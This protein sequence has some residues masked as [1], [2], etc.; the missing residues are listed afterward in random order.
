MIRTIF[1]RCLVLL[2]LALLSLPASANAQLAASSVPY[3]SGFTMVGGPPGTDFSGAL[4]LFAY[5]PSGYSS[6]AVKQATLCGGYWAYFSQPTQVTIPASAGG[7]QACPLQ[8]GWNLVGNP[9]QTP[10]ALPAGLT[11][12]YWDTTTNQYTTVTSIPVGGAVWVY[13]SAPASIMLSTPGTVII[14]SLTSPGPYTAHVGDIVEL[15]IPAQPGYM[16]SA[17]PVYLQLVGAGVTGPLSCL[18][19]SC[20]L[21]LNNNFFKWK[22]IQAGTTAI[23]VSPLCLRTVPPCGLPS[24]AISVTILP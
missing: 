12:F 15:L 10:A 7:T 18:G 20:A 1:S 9:F 21:S 16:A 4:A 2:G 3:A 5:G 6:P 23:A 17:D 8:Q 11:G 22:A 24:Y 13:T 14:S 19:N